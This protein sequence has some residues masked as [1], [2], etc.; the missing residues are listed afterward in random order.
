MERAAPLAAGFNARGVLVPYPGTEI[1]D[2]NH[3]R[4][5]FTEWWIREAPIDYAPFPTTWSRAELVRAYASDAALARNFFRHPPHR[6]RLIESA[7]A[8]KAELTLAKV[9]AA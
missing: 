1:Y 9:N 2:C 6:L 3:E 5:G 8:K 4:F 7:L